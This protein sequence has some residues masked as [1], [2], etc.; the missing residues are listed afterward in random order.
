M[1]VNGVYHPQLYGRKRET[2]ILQECF[3]NTHLLRP[4]GHESQLIVIQGPSGVGKCALAAT[5]R[6]LVQDVGGVFLSGRTRSPGAIAVQVEPLNSDRTKKEAP[7]TT[8]SIYDSLRAFREALRG[9]ANTD[10]FNEPMMCVLQDELKTLKFSTLEEKSALMS[11]LEPTVVQRLFLSDQGTDLRRHKNSTLP[12]YLKSKT[13]PKELCDV[14]TCFI[15]TVARC[16]PLVLLVER[17]DCADKFVLQVIEALL[18]NGQ[19]DAYSKKTGLLI[20]TTCQD[21]SNSVENMRAF[22]QRVEKNQASQ[23]F[24]FCSSDR[25]THSGLIENGNAHM[26]QLSPLS[27]ED[28]LNWVFAEA[29]SLRCT[30]ENIRPVATAVFEISVGNPRLVHWLLSYLS[31][32]IGNEHLIEITLDKLRASRSS[33]TDDLASLVIQNLDPNVR[34]VV[35]LVAALSE[36]GGQEIDLRIVNMVLQRQCIDDVQ[37]AHG[38]DIVKFQNGAIQFTSPELQAVI[39]ALIPESKR[40]P[41]HLRIGRDLWEHSTIDTENEDSDEC[42]LVLFRIAQN[43]HC[44]LNL[45]TGVGEL[46]VIAK[47]NLR[48]GKLAMQLSCFSDATI[49]FDRAIAALGDRHWSCE[50]YDISLMLCNCRS[51]ACYCTADF[52]GMNKSIEEILTNAICFDD[53]LQAYSTKVYADGT[54]HRLKEA[55]STAFYVL[56]ELGEHFPNKPG[57]LAVLIDYIKTRLMLQ[58]KSDR[59]LLGLPAATDVKKIAAMQMLKFVMFYSYISNA[60]LGALAI[61]RMIQLSLKFGITTPAIPAFAAFGFLLS[62]QLDRKVEGV[63]FGQLSLSMLG[64]LDEINAQAWLPRTYFIVYGHLNCWVFPARESLEPLMHAH[65]TA[66]QTGDLEFSIKTASAYLDMSFYSGKQ[67]VGMEKETRTMLLLMDSLGQTSGIV[68]ML[69]LWQMICD[70]MGVSLPPLNL[71]SGIVDVESALESASQ[72]GN[73]GALWMFYLYRIA[74]FCHDGEHARCLETLRKLMKVHDGGFNLWL[75]FYEGVSSLALAQISKGLSRWRLFLR[76]RKAAKQMKQWAIFCPTNCQNKQFLLE[77]EIAALVGRSTSALSL[78]NQ[79]INAAKEE[80]FLGEEGLA[81]E[82]LALYCLRLGSNNE[83]AVNFCKAGETYNHW[84]STTCSKRI[85]ESLERLEH[86]F[87]P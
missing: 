76:G 15:C 36:C 87:V 58:G 70:L 51:E 82:R 67:L 81:Y 1:I 78:F 13:S 77:A 17:I 21:D 16:I 83:A 55:L 56:K 37:I 33:V 84:G 44:G 73:A 54:R 38:F 34:A 18:L 86:P 10:S 22:L 12:N 46:D 50:S 64:N 42:S 48:A 39:Y 14:L 25:A 85:N 45:V 8:A 4:K 11:L 2:A 28:I 52:Y 20:V 53:K 74:Y 69:P 31:L 41:F 32:D 19:G 57:R 66:L 60:E 29:K 26:M 7:T 43:L 63:H 24:S 23:K 72:E 35:D 59:F 6:P 5:L 68:F 47:I 79:S 27:Q 40:A 30:K 65:H 3:S 75:Q 62:I 61:C 9:L 49:Y 80:G 71:T